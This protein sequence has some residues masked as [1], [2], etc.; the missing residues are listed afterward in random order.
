MGIT[1]H[2]RTRSACY[3]HCPVCSGAFPCPREAS[4]GT[5]QFA[6]AADAENGPNVRDAKSHLQIGKPSLAAQ[7]VAR[8][9]DK[10]RRGC[11]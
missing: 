1:R 11:S 2:D 9:W 5:M 3:I 6:K 7:A 10:M 8:R 4:G